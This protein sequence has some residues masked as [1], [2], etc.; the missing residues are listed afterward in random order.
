MTGFNISVPAC[1]TIGGTGRIAEADED[2][3]IVAEDAGCESGTG[4]TTMGNMT[5]EGICGTFGVVEE[6][7]IEEA[8]KPELSTA[9]D[10]AEGLEGGGAGAGAGELGVEEAGITGV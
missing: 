9:E 7:E 6:G 5:F 1:R 3:A 2:D 10:R 4:P 8:G